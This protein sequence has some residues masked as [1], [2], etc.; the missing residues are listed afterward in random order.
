LRVVV[1]GSAAGG[2][3]PQWNCRCPVCSLAWS[4]DARVKRRSQSSIAATADGEAFVLINASPDLR[5]QVIDAPSLQPRDGSRSSP[6]KACV[7]TNA[8]VDHLA[9]LLTLRERQNFA[10]YATS[11]TLAALA[12][13]P[14]FDVLAADCVERKVIRLDEPF[15]PV[16]GLALS[17][18]ATP[19]KV[20][21]WQ[22]GESVEIGGVGEGSVALELRHDGKRLIYAPACAKATPAFRERISGADVLFFDGTTFTDDELIAAGLMA[23]TAQRMG[24]TPMSGPEGSMAA[25]AGVPI[26]RKIYI[27]INNSNPVLIEDSPERRAVEAAG[28]EVAAD[29]MEIA[30]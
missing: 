26:G 27:H 17:A 23:K 24:H 3:V 16:P 4:G 12:A 7:V 22:E 20:A 10:L 5:Q 2:G 1:L 18:F 6:I 11:A 15:E 13:N 19:G 21:L 29:G 9:G 28:W 14:I 30:L 8:D 25:L